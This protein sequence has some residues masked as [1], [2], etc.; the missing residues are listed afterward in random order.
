M[1]D[2]GTQRNPWVITLIVAL[3]GALGAI[4]ATVLP[5]LLNPD[6]TAPTPNSSSPDV[7][8]GTTPINKV[9]IHAEAAVHRSGDLQVVDDAGVA[10]LAYIT[11]GAWATYE[12]EGLGAGSVQSI[13]ANVASATE[14]G[15]IDIRLDG[16]GGQLIGRCS[17]PNTGGWTSWRVV[18]CDV[19]GNVVSAP[20]EIRLGFSGTSSRE[21]PYLFNLDWVK[22]S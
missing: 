7:T 14:G 20:S 8:K 22:F 18:M 19:E 4:G 21:N 1:A 3:I 11:A 15:D 6:P 17:V 16:P 9:T 10:F 2:S 13:T 12:G 5:G